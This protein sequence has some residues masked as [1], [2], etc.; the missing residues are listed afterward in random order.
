MSESSALVSTIPSF[1]RPPVIVELCKLFMSDVVDVLW[2]L[3][4]SRRRWVTVPLE[5]ACM[6]VWYWTSLGTSTAPVLLLLAVAFCVAFCA[7]FWLDWGREAA[8]LLE[9]LEERERP[10][11]EEL[12]PLVF[13]LIFYNKHNNNIII[14]NLCTLISPCTSLHWH[15]YFSAYS[16]S[17]YALNECIHSVF[18]S[19]HQSWS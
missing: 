11:H 13:C 18:L 10:K 8:A 2:L 16:S 7:V 12:T 17:V 5:M 3:L 1:V 19:P 4:L 6:S 9:D 15:Q 14:I